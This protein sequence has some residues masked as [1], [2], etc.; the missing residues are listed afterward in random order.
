MKPSSKATI[1]TYILLL[2][3]GSILLSV[4]SYLQLEYPLSWH[5]CADTGGRDGDLAG[6]QLRYT[7]EGGLVNQL[8]SHLA[9]FV[10]ARQIG[11]PDIHMATV[12]S[13]NSFERY[14]GGNVTWFIHRADTLFD[15]DRMAAHWRQRGLHVHPTPQLR[16][17]E[18][19][20][21]VAK[22]PMGGIPPY[23]PMGC[24]THKL[25][26]GP[27]DRKGHS[28]SVVPHVRR[29]AVTEWHNMTMDGARCLNL[30]IS[31]TFF[32]VQAATERHAFR[33]AFA[34]MFFNR[35]LQNLAEKVQGAI[36]KPYNGLHLRV[37]PDA[38]V[39][40]HVL[41]KESL[42]DEYARAMKA[43]SFAAD[44]P[45]YVACGLQWG[46]STKEFDAV[47]AMFQ[48][49]ESSWGDKFVYKEKFLDKV[50]LEGLHSEQIALV[51]LL[52]LSLSESFVGH[53]GSTF[54]VLIE[55]IRLSDSQKASIF[56]DLKWMTKQMN[57]IFDRQA[58]FAAE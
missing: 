14:A 24:R 23:K 22:L 1:G 47:V 48:N 45:I 39:W 56:I 9:A 41:D 25:E 46:G 10:I 7:V 58:R 11:V 21:Y 54:S 43:G 53:P 32:Q 6:V 57:T 15:L 4:A 26:L 36:G 27:W 51:D 28:L 35:R 42:I 3:T 40:N 38:V 52:V 5:R 49:R 33:E 19:A 8:Y 16:A 2:A 55:Q 30:D 13:R 29:Q 17:L 31:C 37:E 18:K 34:G 20:A 12:M 50:D 44:A